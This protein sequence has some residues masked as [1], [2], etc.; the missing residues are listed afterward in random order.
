MGKEHELQFSEE[1]KESVDRPVKNA[2]TITTEMEIE[3]EYT[4]MVCQRA[5]E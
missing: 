4:L 2:F 3:S 1:D 5:K